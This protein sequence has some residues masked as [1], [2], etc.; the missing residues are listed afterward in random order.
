MSQSIDDICNSAGV[1]PDAF[2]SGH[3]HNYQRYTRR[4]GGKQVPYI[5]IGTGGI[6]PQKVPDANGQPFGDSNQTTYDAAL[7]SYGYLYVTASAKELKFEF[8]PLTDNTHSQAYDP[9]T[10]DLGTHVLTRG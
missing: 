7:R 4:I 3:A 10:V 1:T 2:L 5:V 9:F 8:W 6:A